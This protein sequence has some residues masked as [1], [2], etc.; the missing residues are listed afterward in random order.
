FQ[1]PSLDLNLTGE[2]NVRLHAILYELYPF[3]PSFATMP[4]AYK[5]QLDGLAAV[6]G[7]DHEIFRPVK[8]YSGGMQRKL[9]II[10]SL[11]HQPQVLFLDEPTV[12]LDPLSR[13]SLWEYLTQVRREHQTTILLTTH[14]LDE[15]EQADRVGILNKGSMIALGTPGEV[16]AALVRHYVLIDAA[17]R[18]ALRAELGRLGASFSG[19]GPFR[20]DAQGP[21]IHQL[22]RQITTPLSLVQTHSP[23]LEDAYLEMVGRDNEA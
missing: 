14:Y 7:L 22:L 3:R 6:L 20:V 16:K 12:G 21:G 19:G 4:G 15:A 2:E 11:M 17:G 10:R 13:R 8:T 18:D 5:Q 9:E 23:T 1:R